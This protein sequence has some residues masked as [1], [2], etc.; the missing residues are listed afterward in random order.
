MTVNDFS[1]HLI[2]KKSG[3]SATKKTHI[4]LVK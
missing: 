4:V 1:R 3:T 2:V